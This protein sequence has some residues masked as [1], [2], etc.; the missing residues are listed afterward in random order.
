MNY[1]HTPHC[2]D[3]NLLIIY[4]QFPPCYMQLIGAELAERPIPPSESQKKDVM[5][6][7]GA[8]HTIK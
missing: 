7:S 5:S 4:S 3:C 2:L 6:P 8:V 1:M